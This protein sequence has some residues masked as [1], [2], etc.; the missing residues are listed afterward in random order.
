VKFFAGY[1]EAI[2]VEQVDIGL[3]EGAD[4]SS[5]IEVI[6]EKHP[7]LGELTET[8]VISVNWEYATYD[9]KLEDGDEVALLPPVSGG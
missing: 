3:E 4:V 1:K 5:L 2:G 6:K 7:K 8:L 9:T